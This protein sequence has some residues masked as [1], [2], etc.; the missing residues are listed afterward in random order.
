MT[1][2]TFGIAPNGDEASLY[3]I[4]SPSG[5]GMSLTDWGAT[6]VS[7]R[8]PDRL[9]NIDQITLGF[10]NAASYLSEKGY[11]G[12]T[13]GRFA[14][15]IAKGRFTLEGQKYELVC[16]DG[17]NHLHGGDVGFNARL[18]QAEPYVEGDLQ[19]V[20]FSYVSPDAEEGYPGELNV[21]ANHALDESGRLT[22]EFLAESDKSTI[23]NLT[24]H[25]YWNL[26]G[27]RSNS[28]LNHRLLFHASHYLPVDETA[29]PTGEIK[30]VENSPFDFRSEKVIGQNISEVPGGYDHCMVID[31]EDGEIKTALSL[32][33]PESGRRLTLHTDRPGVQFYTGNFLTGTP[34]PENS[35]LCLEPQDFPDAP[36]KPRFPSTVLKARELYHHRSFIDFSAEPRR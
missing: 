25:S 34:F 35:G 27:V 11:L 33:D 22:M 8:Q 6:I 26:A 14:N 17:Q 19:G 2:D 12:A 9:G 7:V 18:W 21:R 24:N 28:I 30:P 29:I 32:T 10:S 3:N 16:N 5:L 36:N 15:R 4:E 31:G 20:S 23:I 1:I 13:C